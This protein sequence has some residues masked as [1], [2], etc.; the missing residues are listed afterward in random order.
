VVHM[1]VG[2]SYVSIANAQQNLSTEIPAFDFNAVSSNANTAW[3]NILN[4]IQVSGVTTANMQQFYTALYH[5]FQSRNVA[6]DVNG[7]YMGF[8]RAVHPSSRTI[9]QN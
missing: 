6:S 4:R 5:V 9:Y 8:D 7:Q 2:L 1:K 3:N